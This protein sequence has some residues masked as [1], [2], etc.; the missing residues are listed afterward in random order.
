MEC[1]EA[2]DLMGDALEHALSG[3]T[4]LGFEEHIGECASC[5]A[6]FDQ[7]QVTCTVLRNLPPPRHRPR[8][9]ELLTAFRE[10]GSPPS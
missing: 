8:W 5:G 10:R 3:A 9:L 4:R 1:P 2:I 7:L 6:F